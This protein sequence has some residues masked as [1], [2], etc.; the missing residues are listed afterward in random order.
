[1][2]E[3]IISKYLKNNMLS[4]EVR[5]VVNSLPAYADNCKRQFFL[6]RAT[7]GCIIFQSTCGDI[8]CYPLFFITFFFLFVLGYCCGVS[9]C[10]L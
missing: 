8:M 1:M 6:S 5:H 3:G 9:S 7:F 10:K 2:Q 4:R